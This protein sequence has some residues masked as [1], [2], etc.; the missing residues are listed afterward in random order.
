MTTI[1]VAV[2]I[3][4]RRADYCSRPL[5][6]FVAHGLVEGFQLH[7]A[8]GYEAFDIVFSERPCEFYDVA[9]LRGALSLRADIPSS[10]IGN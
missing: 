1:A 4:R 2:S 8:A 6:E 3:Q 7:H 5:N 10:G 9:I